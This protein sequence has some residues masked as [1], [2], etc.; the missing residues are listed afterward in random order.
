VNP[1]HSTQQS[2]SSSTSVTPVV[3][4][5]INVFDKAELIKLFGRLADAKMLLDVPGLVLSA[6]FYGLTAATAT[7]TTIQM[8]NE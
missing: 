6:I 3:D 2:S 4:E 5:P 1:L 7:V 8:M